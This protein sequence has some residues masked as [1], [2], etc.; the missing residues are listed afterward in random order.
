[1]IVDKKFC[2]ARA[3]G[4]VVG[5]RWFID[6]RFPGMETLGFEKRDAWVAKRRLGCETAPRTQASLSRTQASRDGWVE[7]ET[8]GFF[9]DETLGL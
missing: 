2:R 8:L 9:R 7:A 1:L 5:A 6:S 3:G 4:V